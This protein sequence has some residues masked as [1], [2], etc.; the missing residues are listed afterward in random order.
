[1]VP[2]EIIF[3]HFL[4][5][6]KVTTDSRS[7]P[8]GALFFALRGDRFDGHQFV[9]EA[10][11]Q[12]ASFAIVDD[13]EAVSSDECLLVPDVLDALQQLAV[14]YRSKLKATLIGITGSNGKT[15]TKELIYCVLQKKYKTQATSGNYNNH[16][17]VPLTLLSFPEDLEFGIVEMGANHVGEIALLSGFSNP[18]YGIITNVGKAH[19]EG[20][21]SFEGVV[22]GKS[23]LYRQLEKNGGTAFVNENNPILMDKSQGLTR[24][25]YGGENNTVHG[26]TQNA[27]PFLKLDCVVNEEKISINT[28][29]SGAFNLENILAAACIGHHFG[30]ETQ[31]IKEAI[32]AYIPSNNRSQTVK[33]DKNTIILDAYNANPTSMEAAVRNFM[34]SD[35]PEKILILGE[36]LELGKDSKDEHRKILNLI[37]DHDFKRVILVGPNFNV[38]ESK[39]FEYFPSTKNLL[40]RLK[41]DPIENTAMLIKGSRGNEL[42][43]VVDYL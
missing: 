41:T 42:E 28:R 4:K 34:E 10:L 21:G 16:I 38:N 8:E 32:E 19:L 36:M 12:G 31:D 14:M 43:Q 15:T 9:R 30:V 6:H 3:K 33:T 27:H 40:D 5:F 17:G 20:F 39:A 26:K 23:E 37:K 24:I 1:M 35:F 2:V 22:R 29:L 25:L 11:V 13:P 7:I 18:D